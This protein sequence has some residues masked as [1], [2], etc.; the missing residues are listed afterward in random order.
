MTVEELIEICHQGAHLAEHDFED[1]VMVQLT[2]REMWLTVLGYL[3]LS[4][5]AECLAG[6]CSE[7]LERYVELIDVQKPNWRNAQ[8]D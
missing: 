6:F 7:T 5:S 1:T 4:Q 2:R 3:L 8:G